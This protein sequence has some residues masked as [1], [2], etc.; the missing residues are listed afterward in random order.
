MFCMV[1]SGSG[2][3]ARRLTRRVSPLPRSTRFAYAG[4]AFKSK[5]QRR[6][7]PDFVQQTGYPGARPHQLLIVRGRDLRARVGGKQIPWGDC[8]R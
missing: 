1:R 8:Q 4:L 5:T 7:R 3:G 2:F 6:M